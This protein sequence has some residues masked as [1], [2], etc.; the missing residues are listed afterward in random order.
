MTVQFNDYAPYF[1]NGRLFL[2]EGTIA[3]LVE[4]GLDA[5]IGETA[6]TGLDLGEHRAQI[7]VIS[8]TLESALERMEEDSREF[9]ALSAGDI[10]FMLTGKPDTPTS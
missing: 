1:R 9:R 3:L 4:A 6:R 10:Q 8:R 5:Q 7:A 2:P